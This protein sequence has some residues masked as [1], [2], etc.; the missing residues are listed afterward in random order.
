MK[1]LLAAIAV[2]LISVSLF[3]VEWNAY[4]DESNGGNSTAVLSV[5]DETI[6]GVA[7]KNVASVSGAVTTQYQYGF[8]CL[9]LQ[10]PAFIEKLKKGSGIRVTYAGDGKSYDLRLETPSVIKDYAWARFTLVTDKKGA[11]KT[12]DLKWN[13]FKQYEWGTQV[14]YTPADIENISFQTIG[15]PLASYNLKIISIEVL[16]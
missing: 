8:A 7:Y 5:A 16:E 2:A 13:K 4:G 15:Q 6:G 14:K 12:V 11:A 1:K 3:A 9:E 10:D